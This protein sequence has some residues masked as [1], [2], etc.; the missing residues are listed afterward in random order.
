LQLRLEAFN[1]TNTQ[2]MNRPNTDSRTGWGVGLDPSTFELDDIPVNFGRFTGIQ[3]APRVLQ[4]GVR[5]FF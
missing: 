5:Y 4:F 1:V 2:R 3:G